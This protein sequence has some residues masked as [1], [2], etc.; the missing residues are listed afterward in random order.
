MAQRKDVHL[1]VREMPSILTVTLQV[2]NGKDYT[3]KT[4]EFELE[5]DISSLRSQIQKAAGNKSKRSVDGP[6][7]IKQCKEVA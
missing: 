5:W 7:I 1:A 3:P 2:F 4:F 6:I